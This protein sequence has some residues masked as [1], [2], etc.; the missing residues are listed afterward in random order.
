[1]RPQSRHSV[2]HLCVDRTADAIRR[3]TRL[4]KLD[5]PTSIF[6]AL[7]L[8]TS[9]LTRISLGHRITSPLGPPHLLHAVGQGALGVE[10][11]SRDPRVREVLR[12][13]GHWQT[14][15]TCAAERG[16]L[17]VLEG[18]CSVP[19]G[20][21][22]SLEELE[23]DA[24]STDSEVGYGEEGFAPLT[25]ESPLLHFS[26]ILPFSTPLPEL[27]ASSE[28]VKPVL[29]RRRAR[30][31]LTASV[32]SPDGTKHVVHSPEAVVVASY[33]GA[34]A[35]GEEVARELR[36][37]GAGEILDEV[38]RVRKEREA[39]DLEAKRAA[40]AAAAA[41]EGDAQGDALVA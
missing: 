8:A 37:L 26:G 9:G 14:E 31:S 4:A 16:C 39:K 20:V 40:A 29:V 28:E 30:L 22:S 36:R 34:E 33:R 38:N 15:W 3:N 21:E 10:I 5:S 13:V 18:G 2:T 35:W 25:G 12:G 27:N 32:T 7:I 41:A 23:S 24:S 6:S 1:L 17:R 11:R 19:V